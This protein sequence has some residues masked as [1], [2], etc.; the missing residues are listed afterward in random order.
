M[1][2]LRD[3]ASGDEVKYGK[4]PYDGPGLRI[5]DIPL[6]PYERRAEPVYVCPECGE[7]AP[8]VMGVMEHLSRH[9]GLPEWHPALNGPSFVACVSTAQMT[10][11]RR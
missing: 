2:D 8:G 9:S 11:V 5:E 7:D 6:P 3:D 1:P 10:W 4:P